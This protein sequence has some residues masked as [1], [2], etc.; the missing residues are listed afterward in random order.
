MSTTKHFV[1]YTLTHPLIGD[2]EADV[3]YEI[4]DPNGEPFIR[5]H[6]VKIDGRCLSRPMTRNG[7]DYDFIGSPKQV[8]EQTIVALIMDEAY[9][10]PD[11]TTSILRNH[12]YEYRGEGGNDPDGSWVRT[13]QWEG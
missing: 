5:I 7:R 10:N 11:W 2:V 12:G 3:Q 9:A 13:R 6:G 8:L 1:E 4:D